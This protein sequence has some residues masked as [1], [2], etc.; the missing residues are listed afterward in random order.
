MELLHSC[1]F[2]PFY[3]ELNLASQIF[4][5]WIIAC[6]CIGTESIS[7]LSNCWKTIS[8][9]SCLC[10]W[11][12]HRGLFNISLILHFF[13]SLFLHLSL[14]F[15]K[16]YPKSWWSFSRLQVSSFSTSA[17]TGKAPI[18]NLRKPAGC[19]ERDYIRWKNCL[20]RDFTVN[21]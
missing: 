19:D 14:K 13:L 7:P 12:Y 15:I 21:G 6:V 11:Y 8:H 20:Q 1:I 18:K 4:K 3:N 2:S 5:Y 10:W 16:L 17:R 9:M